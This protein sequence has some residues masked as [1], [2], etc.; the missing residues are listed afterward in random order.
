MISLKHLLILMGTISLLMTVA[1]VMVKIKNPSHVTLAEVRAID[2][3]C[4]RQA[5]Q[6]MT[7]IA[8][9]ATRDQVTF[10]KKLHT[11][12]GACRTYL[13]QSRGKVVTVGGLSPL[14]VPECFGDQIKEEVKNGVELNKQHKGVKGAHRE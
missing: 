5:D 7:R 4:Q 10:L 14:N 11:C 12:M 8:S 1:V 13:V 9:E 6:M 2:R 3:L